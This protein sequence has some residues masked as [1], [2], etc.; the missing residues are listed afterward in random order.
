[1]FAA[2]KKYSFWTK[3]YLEG[4]WVGSV[5]D[6]G[7]AIVEKWKRWY[8]YDRIDLWVWYGDEWLKRALYWWKR[9]VKWKIMSSW[10]TVSFDYKKVPAPDWAT[11]NLT[12]LPSVFSKWIWSDSSN[13]DIKELQRFLKE[14]WF[15]S[16]NI[17]WDYSRIHDIVLDFQ[18]K[19]RIVNNKSAYGAGYW[20]V[21]TR[22]KFR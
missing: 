12:K 9:V 1:M 3:I 6:R 16:G 8:E 21:K 14:E 20:W 15:Y 11:K 10:E 17:D 13:D 5:E 19:H 22:G 7:W 2:P 18:L 4:L